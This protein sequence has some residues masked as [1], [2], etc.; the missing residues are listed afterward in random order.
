MAVDFSQTVIQLRAHLAAKYRAVRQAEAEVKDAE[1]VLSWAET[2]HAAI[3]AAQVQ[4]KAE[5]TNS[6]EPKP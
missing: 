6:E 5:P 4:P 3:V 2:A 1:A